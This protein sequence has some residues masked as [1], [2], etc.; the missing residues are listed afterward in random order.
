MGY[1][2][3]TSYDA[4]ACADK[5]T[6]IN[7]CQAF[8]IYFERDPTVNPDD[9][10]CSNPASTTQI[11]CVYWSGPVTNDNANN[12]GQWRNK[13][14]V[15]I[16]GSNGYVN[17]SIATPDGYNAGVYLNNAA[18]NA[19]LDCTGDD[20][21]LESHVFN[22]KPFDANLCA[23]ACNS[24]ANY[25]RATAQDGKFT[26]A[27]NFFNTYLLY[28]NK[29]NI[30]QYCALYDQSWASS[31]AKNTGY[32]YGQDVYTVGFS[33]SFSNK[34]DPGQPRYPCAVASA[35]SAISSATLQSYCSSI[36]TLAAATTQIVVYTPTVSATTLTTLSGANAKRAASATP[37]A[38]QK[39]AP[40]VVTQAC[41][42]AVTSGATAT[43]TTTASPTTVYI[44]TSVVP[45]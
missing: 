25:A 13:F 36:L 19:P 1:T 14:Q 35:K 11:K 43:T 17:K 26:K 6:K 30:G 27:C 16:A 3:L 24:Q 34:T 4:Q 9:S 15:V 44:A 28:K 12:A 20:T 40:S 18:I 41:G 8:N 37:S 38:L 21:F 10:S 42:L 32:Y 31:Y 7:G 29:V 22:N 39:Y 5:C 45:A 2:L 33:Y 23:A